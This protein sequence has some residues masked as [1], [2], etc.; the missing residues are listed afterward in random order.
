MEWVPSRVSLDHPCGECQRCDTTVLDDHSVKHPNFELK[1]CDPLE[2]I[3]FPIFEYTALQITD[4]FTLNIIPGYMDLQIKREALNRWKRLILDLPKSDSEMSTAT[5]DIETAFLILDDF[6]F[7]RSLRDCVGIR[8]VEKFP[9]DKLLGECWPNQGI[10]GKCTW[11]DI[12][13]PSHDRPMTVQYVLETIL[14]EMCHA[15]FTLACTCSVCSCKLN[16]V[17]A[18]G[19][20][21][22]GPCWDRLR[23]TVEETANHH[24]SEFLPGRLCLD[25]DSQGVKDARKAK[26]KMLISLAAKIERQNDPAERLK[27]AIRRR[28]AK[29]DEPNTPEGDE[30]RRRK[31]EV[32]WDIVAM[33]GKPEEETQSRSQNLCGS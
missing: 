5:F 30:I 16:L 3:D 28:K 17:N 18:A 2:G 19:L 24:L 26:F 9:G 22:H 4:A 13:K 31:D 8:W 32:L 7:L 33:F 12:L 23:T 10:R 29:E 14:H 11:I 15:L 27:K 21:G 25:F 20:E 6:L 1:S